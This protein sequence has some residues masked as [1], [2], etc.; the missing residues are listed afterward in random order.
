MKLKLILLASLFLI[1]AC[2]KTPITEE[3]I[4]GETVI[5]EKNPCADIVCN[6]NQECVDGNCV[7]EEDFRLC[8]GDCISEQQ[9]CT[10]EECSKIEIC[11]VNKCVFSCE[12]V[13]CLHNQV[14]EEDLKKCVCAPNTRLCNYQKKCLKYDR[15][16][17]SFDCEGSKKCTLTTFSVNICFEED[18]QRICKYVGENSFIYFDLYGNR[19]K[20]SLDKIYANNE[21]KYSIDDKPLQKIKLGDRIKLAPRLYLYLQEIKE[22]G[23]ICE[24]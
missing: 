5:E 1:V 14:C 18:K 10:D 7:C 19:Y 21:I 16:C 11:E 8:K 13:L 9:C 6:E 20:F 17:D 4:T 23:G 3:K 12:K 15:C 22:I 2:T 24:Y